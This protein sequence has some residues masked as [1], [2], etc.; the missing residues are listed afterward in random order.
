[1]R[2]DSMSAPLPPQMEALISAMEKASAKVAQVEARAYANPEIGKAI[3]ANAL[4]DETAARDSLREAIRELQRDKERLDWMQSRGDALSVSDYPRAWDAS[5]NGDVFN[6][7][8]TEGPF[9]EKVREAIDAARSQV[10]TEK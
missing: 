4:R 10:R 8:P 1:M 3:L 7:T 6:F 5:T 2:E 9:F